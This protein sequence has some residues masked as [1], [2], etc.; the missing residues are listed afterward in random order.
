M[1]LLLLFFFV[2]IFFSFLCSI[3]EA[4]LLSIPPSFVA[5]G[6]KEG[7]RTG[8]ILS[9]FKEDVDRPLAA[10]LTLNTIAHTVGAIGVG[11]Q[12][13][14]LFSHA[15]LMGI[16]VAAVIVPTVMT[17]AILI[18][19]EIIP[20]TLGAGYWRGLAGFTASSLQLIIFILYPLV[21]L[22]QMITRLLK[23]DGEGSVLSRSE[24][25][26]M[27]EVI[28]EQGVLA[29]Q[30]S[31]IIKSLLRFSS[32]RAGDVMTPRTVVVA[33]EGRQTVGE[34][35][36]AHKSVRLS[37]IPLFDG[38]I[39]TITG[40][41]IRSDILRRMVEGQDDIPLKELQRPILV[42]NHD[43]PL[44]EVFNTLIEKRAHIAVVI[45]KYGGTAGILTM[46]DVVETLLGLE[47]VDEF[48]RTADM[49]QLARQNWEVRARNLGLIE[50]DKGP[51]DLTGLNPGQPS[52]SD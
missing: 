20:K 33:A 42:V 2:S 11:A 24:F 46:E 50:E 12:A 19:S 31:G 35:Y 37:R 47:I 28:A 16:N 10:I 13:S 21:V 44:P 38:S 45:D 14:K 27:T 25:S 43:Q 15:T 32:V 51:G 8:L 29:R 34:F 48:D 30:E 40:F 41:M 52:A 22:S 18:L 9:R 4:V 39:D 3:W 49:Q 26:A 6:A 7:T 17:L 36:A 1:E 23:K 5:A